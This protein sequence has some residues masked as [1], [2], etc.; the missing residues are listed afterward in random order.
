ME[1][2]KAKN[3]QPDKF[4]N[5][6]VMEYI[7]EESD[8][9]MIIDKIAECYPYFRKCNRYKPNEPYKPDFN[10]LSKLDTLSYQMTDAKMKGWYKAN[11]VAKPEYIKNLIYSIE[12]LQAKEPERFPEFVQVPV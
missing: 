1:Q 7:T 2:K 6:D 10:K 8:I 3:E 12:I 9:K 4:I 5:R 11:R